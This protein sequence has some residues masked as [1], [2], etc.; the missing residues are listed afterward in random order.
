MKCLQGQLLVATHRQLDPNFARTVILVIEHDVRGAFG[1]IV[2]RPTRIG[3]LQSRVNEHRCQVDLQLNLGGPVTGPLMVLHTNRFLAEIEVSPGLFFSAKDG[4]VAGLLRQRSRCHRA[5]VGYTGWGSGQLE[6]ELEKGMWI[7][8]PATDKYVFCEG[9]N[10]WGELSK[11]I[12]E[13]VL[14]ILFHMRHIP[15]DPLLN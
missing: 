10:L 1:V 3:V 2:N 9:E 12:S 14:R 15:Q 8:V 6:D 4:N 11:Q 5:F 7:T 13:S